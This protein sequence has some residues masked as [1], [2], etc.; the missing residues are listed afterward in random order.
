MARRIKA[1]ATNIIFIFLG[2]CKVINARS[3]AGAWRDRIWVSLYC[4]ADHLNEGRCYNRFRVYLVSNLSLDIISIIDGGNWRASVQAHWHVA[5]YVMIGTIAGA[6]ML[7]VFCRSC[8]NFFDVDDRAL[9]ATEK[10]AQ[11]RLV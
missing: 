9:C 11:C 4:H 8:P 5:L 1:R 6:K 2:C 3:D 7:Q 10:L